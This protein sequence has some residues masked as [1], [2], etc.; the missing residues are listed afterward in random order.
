MCIIISFLDCAYE[1]GRAGQPLAAHARG[2]LVLVIP[3]IFFGGSSWTPSEL[4][5]IVT[6]RLWH[7]R[8]KALSCV[9]ICKVRKPGCAK[10]AV[11]SYFIF[12]IHALIG[13]A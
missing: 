7:A 10:M 13:I 9:L 3:V 11:A 12:F 1:M 8:R 4:L 6:P 2:V 5:W